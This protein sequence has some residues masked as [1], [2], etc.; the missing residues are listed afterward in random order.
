MDD[1]CLSS[2]LVHFKHVASTACAQPSNY[3]T[4]KLPNYQTLSLH[5]V[6]GSSN[7]FTISVLTPSR[8][9]LRY[10]NYL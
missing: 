1:K 3:S 5:I 7:P 9:K 4:I 10:V 6:N 2:F 8:P